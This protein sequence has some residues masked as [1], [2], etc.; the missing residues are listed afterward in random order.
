MV[1]GL[2]R[3][4]ARAARA[5]VAFLLPLACPQPAPVASPSDLPP[6]HLF[7]QSYGTE[8]G[9][10]NLADHA[11]GQDAEGFLWIGSQEGLFRYDGT[12]FE[13]Y[14]IE[15]GLPSAYVGAI[16]AVPDGRLLVGT[17]RGVAA[18]EGGRWRAIGADAGLPQA[19]INTIVSGPNSRVWVAS[20]AGA[21][22]EAS[23][24]RFE[25]VPGLPP[26]EVTGLWIDPDGS[27]FIGQDSALHRLDPGGE[28]R[29]W[30]A[31]AGLGP[32]PVTGVA[33]DGAGLLWLHSRSRLWVMG[34]DGDIEDR[35][36]LL[37]TGSSEGG[38]ALDRA[39]NVLV[40][41]ARGVLRIGRD[42]AEIINHQRG[43]PTD[44]SF[45]AF[46]D[47]EGSLWIA[48][49]G[50]HRL[51]GRGLWAAYTIA[52]GLPNNV[53]YS[54]SRGPD[55][56]LWAGTD[57]GLARSGES[58]F[59]LV[60]GTEGHS[61]RALVWAPD[62]A[63]W[64]GG[65]PGKLLRIDPASLAIRSYGPAEGLR[66]AQIMG[67]TRDREGRFWVGMRGGGV[68]RGSEAADGQGLR[69]EPFPLPGGKPD[70]EIDWVMLDDRGRVLAAG[71]HGLAVIEGDRARRITT[72]DGLRSD[73]VMGVIQRRS[74][75]ICVEYFE[76]L[77]MSCFRD[78]GSGASAGGAVSSASAG[79][80]VSGASAGGAVSGASGM[81]HLGTKEGLP[82]DKV[83]FM[84]EDSRDRLWLGTAVG[85]AVL[86]GST[87]IDTFRQSDGTPGDDSDT[88]AFWADA[89][90]DVWIGTST[91][92]GRFAGA[93]YRGPPEPPRSRIAAASFGDARLL[94]PFPESVRVPHGSG[95]LSVRF[96]AQS[97]VNEARVTQEVR[98]VGLE[99][100]WRAAV[101]REE[102]YGALAPRGYRFEVRA[103]FANGAPGPVAALSFEIL[104]AWWQTLWARGLA[105]AALAGALIGGVRLRLRS[106]S[107]KN[108]ELERVVAARTSELRAAQERVAEAEKLSALGRL[109]AQLSHELNNPINVISNNIE[110]M[111]AYLDELSAAL[112]ALRP[113]IEEAPGAREK[114]DRLWSDLEIDFVTDDFRK[115]LNVVATATG[116]VRGIH[117][118]LRTFMHGGVPEMARGDLAAAAREAVEM[119][120]RGLPPGVSV[121]ERYE[122]VPEV[123]FHAGQISQVL[124]NLLQNAADAVGAEGTITVTAR[125]DD[126]FVEVAVEDSGPGIPEPLRTRVFEPFFTTKDVGKGTGL[127]LSISREIVKNHGGTIELQAPPS[128]G[129]R[130]VLRLPLGAS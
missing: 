69:F 65:S 72:A 18:W 87:V 57:D 53:I 62:G 31:E 86:E 67:F 93:R 24:G 98:L 129:A 49:V 20:K 41:T 52:E 61:F 42:V 112:A 3:R 5:R 99:D 40:P 75:E 16:Y 7:F 108:E 50:V 13:R 63:L 79:G 8:Q 47:R 119:A 92:L 39:Q 88:M 81:R 54:I 59:R 128:G 34:E 45:A 22:R 43:L 100:T 106:L 74:G 122:E 117:A 38:L 55:G 19:T 44:E 105:L 97:F 125:A 120:A 107:K 46:E 127:G 12:R 35:T 14:G 9:I 123:S 10:Q 56:R 89:D 30:G 17:W 95:P 70:E 121:V 21:F 78:A 51:R 85:V 11:F 116:R 96:S 71:E 113:I 84:G 80:A 27:A 60:P 4:S 73:H 1:S 2:W 32:G 118:D 64:G 101:G 77:G 28:L 124:M 102:R 109:L 58:G 126:G 6:G 82:S 91:G 36:C 66:G 114:L 15:D 83:Y 110:P 94:E 25:P 37:P 23:P 130:F 68:L 104:P 33:R 111:R 29:T 90:G 48:S 76:A 26:G 115:A 103:R